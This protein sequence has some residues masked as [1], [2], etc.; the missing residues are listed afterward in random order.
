MTASEVRCAA[1]DL[2]S[3]YKF[4]LCSEFE[5]PHDRYGVRLLNTSR[6][7]IWIKFLPEYTC[8]QALKRRSRF[9]LFN[10]KIKI[11]HFLQNCIYLH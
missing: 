5:T 10:K 11:L 4:H 9:P 1:N 2:V 7:R 3:T 8:S 6:S